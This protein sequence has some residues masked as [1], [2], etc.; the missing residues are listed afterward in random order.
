MVGDSGCFTHFRSYAVLFP[1]QF[2]RGIT[3]RGRKRI[4]NRESPRINANRIFLAFGCSA[5][6]DACKSK[7]CVPPPQESHPLWKS[8]N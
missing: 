1:I 5:S 4:F 2:E 7:I 6:A 8:P 3:G